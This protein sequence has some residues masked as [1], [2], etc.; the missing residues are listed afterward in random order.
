MLGCPPRM[1]NS[2]SDDLE[3]DQSRL[4][5]HARIIQKRVLIKLFDRLSIRR[6]R[7]NDSKPAVAVSSLVSFCQ[8]GMTRSRNLTN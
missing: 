3:L 6:Q 2:Q 5:A 7:S 8:V 4:Y 1:Q